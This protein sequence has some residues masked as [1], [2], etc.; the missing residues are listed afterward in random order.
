MLLLHRAGQRIFISGDVTR[1][2]KEI[3][4]FLE[5]DVPHSTK[6]I[7]SHIRAQ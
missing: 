1:I 5:I 3:A 4:P 6:D 7:R 2:Y